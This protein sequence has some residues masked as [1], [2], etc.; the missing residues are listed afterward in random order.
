MA[1][2]KFNE[3]E[4]VKNEVCV[5]VRKWQSSVTIINRLTSVSKGHQKE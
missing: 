1:G 2:Q 4:D 5:C 3:D